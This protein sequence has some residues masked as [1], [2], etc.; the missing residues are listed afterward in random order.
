M[1]A[2]LFVPCTIWAEVT[3]VGLINMVTL[4]LTGSAAELHVYSNSKI[5]IQ[6]FGKSTQAMI[7]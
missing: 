6:I 5:G 3:S 7:R 4:R 1:Q 2:S